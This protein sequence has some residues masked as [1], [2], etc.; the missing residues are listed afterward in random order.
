VYNLLVRVTD[1]GGAF[2]TAI[3][4]ITVSD[5]NES[6]TFTDA[7]YA[8]SIDENTPRSPR[9]VGD[10]VGGPVLAA[11]QDA[12]QS[13]T[14][15]FSLVGGNAL[16]YF[17]II[18]TGA[19]RGQIQLTSAG[20]SGLNFETASSFVLSLLVTDTGGLTAS[21]SVTVTIVNRNEHPVMSAQ[22]RAVSE[23]VAVLTSIGAP[24]S[25]SDVD[26]PRSSLRFAITNGNTAGV[27]GIEASSGQLFI[28]STVSLNYEIA[29]LYSLT[30]AVTDT[31][32]PEGVSNALTTTATITISIS[33]VNEA[34]T[35]SPASFSLA[36]N[37]AASAVVG[38]MTFGDVD[39]IDT[40]GQR[41]RAERLVYLLD[42]ERMVA[43]PPAGKQVFSKFRL[44]Q[45][46]SAKPAQAK[47]A[48]SKP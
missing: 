34:P 38:T 5:V 12:G 47:T 40:D 14:L 45:Q 4:T 26:D 16:G 27:F 9:A 28:A 3:L 39:V 44:Q 37:S 13:S 7:T 32:F 11:D 19:N 24:L 30:V 41:L 20:A 2:A 17:S 21:T 36:E 43:E 23:G 18:E 10:N 48:I 1:G 46:G 25:A 31:G 15:S 29:Q 8:R 22:S 42:S 6:P 33:D 35:L